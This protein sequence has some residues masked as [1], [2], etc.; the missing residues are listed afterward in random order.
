VGVPA[1][2]RSADAGRGGFEFIRDLRLELL[3]VLDATGKSRGDQSRTLS[4]PSTMNV[5]PGFVWDFA[6]FIEL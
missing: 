5:R 2:H 4:K 6:R 1:R 3:E